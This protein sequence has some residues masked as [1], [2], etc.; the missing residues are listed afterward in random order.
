MRNL[1]VNES[2]KEFN[3]YYLDATLQEE[4]TV[5]GIGQG[6]RFKCEQ[7]AELYKPLFLTLWVHALDTLHKDASDTVRDAYLKGLKSCFRRQQGE[8]ERVVGLVME[9]EA[10]LDDFSSAS[11]RF[12]AQEIVNK[13]ARNKKDD[14]EMV[15]RL[16]IT[17]QSRLRDFENMLEGVTIITQPEQESSL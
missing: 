7:F 3:R 12:V 14:T 17:V 11:F 10:M 1:S 15:E 16:G 2:I 5:L 8:Y 13:I 4:L 6:R 9:Y